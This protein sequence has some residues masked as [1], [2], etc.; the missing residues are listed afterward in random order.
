MI[1]FS[2]EYLLRIWSCVEDQEFSKPLTGRLKFSFTALA[3]VDLLAILPFY[4][5]M[6]LP[7]DLRLIRGIR[8]F[9]LFRLFKMGRYSQSLRTVGAVLKSQRE[10]LM[11]TVFAVL[12]L[13]VI[14]S[15]ILYFV[16]HEAQPDA[17]SS[18]PHSM[19]WA[20][21]TLTTVGYGDIY[22][23]TSLGK[24]LGAII[25][26]LGIGIFALPAGILASGFSEVIQKGK[27][28]RKKCPHCGEDI[29]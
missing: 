28:G 17:F 25:A 1:V 6:I 5:P 14:S 20:V 29:D 12:M 24:F 3:I 26:F 10:E 4:L 8:L 22:P 9:R 19:W 18:I 7:L 11:I 21:A 2:G 16:E 13:L 15:S 27:V 23:I